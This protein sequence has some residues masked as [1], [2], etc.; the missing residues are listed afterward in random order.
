M[1]YVAVLDDRS[2]YGDDL[3]RRLADQGHSV[4]LVRDVW[5]GIAIVALAPPD[6]LVIDASRRPE[7]TRLDARLLCH[8]AP[9]I[10]LTDSFDEMEEEPWSFEEN[11]FCVASTSVSCDTVVDMVEALLVPL[12]E[13]ALP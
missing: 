8:I 10:L 9:V 4:C 1:A 6:V 7:A 5:L 13:E 11:P 12:P 3:S 2:P